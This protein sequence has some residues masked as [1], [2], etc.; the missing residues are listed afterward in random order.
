MFAGSDM[1]NFK[2]FIISFAA[3]LSFVYSS[4][5]LSNTACLAEFNNNEQ[6]NL[7]DLTDTNTITDIWDVQYRMAQLSLILGEKSDPRGTF[8]VVY[9]VMTD[10]AARTVAEGYYQNNELAGKLLIDFASRYLDNYHAYLSADKVDHH[11]VQYFNLAEDCSR[12]PLRV[13]ASGINSHITIDLAEAVAAIKAP[14]GF[15]DDFELFGSVLVAKAEGINEK[16]FMYYNIDASDFFSGF[17]L[18]QWVDGFVGQGVSTELAFSVVRSQAWLNGRLLQR[19]LFY[20]NTKGLMNIS[21]YNRELLL[22]K[23]QKSGLLNAAP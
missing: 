9:S 11:W 18:G 5:V 19:P 13:A 7:L 17:F 8:P 3:V 6:Q 22:L 2:I 1:F 12:P 21:F 10:E 23:L 20:L 15:Q 16:L 14:K 4:S